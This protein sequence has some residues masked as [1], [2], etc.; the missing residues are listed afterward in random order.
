MLN[1]IQEFSIQKEEDPEFLRHTMNQL[2]EEYDSCMKKI[3]KLI[4]D[5]LTH[6]NNRFAGFIALL[7][8]SFGLY[9]PGVAV[10]AKHLIEK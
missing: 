5:L 10:L 3:Q 8:G 2:H 9:M 4:P 6:F 1:E 7:P